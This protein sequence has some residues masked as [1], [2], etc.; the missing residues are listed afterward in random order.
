MVKK[1]KIY[2]NTKKGV[3]VC[4][5]CGR[6]LQRK[7]SHFMH[8]YQEH[9]EYIIYKGQRLDQYEKNGGKLFNGTKC[10]LCLKDDFASES[11]VI[12]HLHT[13]NN[14]ELRYEI[15]VEYPKKPK[16]ILSKKQLMKNR[17]AYK[18]LTQVNS[19]LI[20]VIAYDKNEGPADNEFKDIRD[21][22]G[23][24]EQIQVCDQL[25]QLVTQEQYFAEF[26]AS[27][28]RTGI[29]Q[30]SNT[31]KFCL[32]H[33]YRVKYA[34]FHISKF[35]EFEKKKYIRNFNNWTLEEKG[36]P[37]KQ[38][39]IKGVPIFMSQDNDKMKTLY[40]KISLYYSEDS[41]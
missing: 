3:W 18:F 15:D 9:R 17:T 21:F 38:I 26:T 34:I 27:D 2:L 13:H 36:T 25:V 31:I 11:S 5:L 16:V 22:L 20:E 14:K 28:V 41:K 8:I 4:S 32:E 24:A 23:M 35:N 30:L 12:R 40:E 10:L 33:G 1:G 39:L 6:E 29:I 7:D 19:L 37:R